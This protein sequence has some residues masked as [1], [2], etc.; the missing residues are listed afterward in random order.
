M[1]MCTNYKSCLYNHNIS[2]LKAQVLT[3]FSQNKASLSTFHLCIYQNRNEQNQKIFVN[4]TLHARNHVHERRPQLGGN[5]FFPLKAYNV[6]KETKC[7]LY[8]I[9]NY[10]IRA[11]NGY[12]ILSLSSMPRTL[13]GD[14]HEKSPDRN[15]YY[16]H[17][18]MEWL[19]L[20][21]FCYSQLAQDQTDSV[22]QK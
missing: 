20:R 14:F 9:N 16:F 4:H 7:I 3:T 19:V 22:Q 6:S 5:L 8:Q 12:H 13:S 2:T 18:K 15:S 10:R 1:W 11:N 21:D 17:F